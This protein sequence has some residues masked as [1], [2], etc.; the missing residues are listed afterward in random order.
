VKSPFSEASC[1]RNVPSANWLS[2]NWFVSETL[3]ASVLKL[4]RN[5]PER[6]TGTF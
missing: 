1:H 5:A 3:I 2:A 6:H 4:S